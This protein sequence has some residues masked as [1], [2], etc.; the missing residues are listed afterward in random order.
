[1]QYSIYFCEIIEQN[2]IKDCKTS[3]ANFTEPFDSIL[4]LTVK[5]R[6]LLT[7]IFSRRSQGRVSR[8]WRCIFSHAKSF[9]YSISSLSLVRSHL[10]THERTVAECGS[11]LR[12]TKH[13][14]FRVMR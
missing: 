3:S 8:C 5:K 2:L 6:N 14:I 9:M 1:L 11:S 13:G 10:V 4:S 7:L 12:L